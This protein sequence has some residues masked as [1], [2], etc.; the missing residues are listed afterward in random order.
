MRHTMTLLAAGTALLAAAPALAQLG[1]D[2]VANVNLV[3]QVGVNPAGTVRD[4][5]APVGNTVD[6]VD[7]MA[8][9][10]IDTT[11]LT[12]ATRGQVRAGAGIYDTSGNSVG[13][14]Q[15]ID[16]GT[17]IVVRDG[18]LYDLPLSAIYHNAADVAHALVTKLPSAQIKARASGG[19]AVES[20]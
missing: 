19:A 16:G 2:G 9:K 11:K 15:S 8:K 13:T 18:K 12:V 7:A 6:R 3:G 17:A 1:A 10:T 20:R 5:T 4:I 14:V